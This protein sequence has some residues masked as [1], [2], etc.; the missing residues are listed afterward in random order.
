MLIGR[1]SR[2]P[3]ALVA[4][5]LAVAA[6]LVLLTGYH[7]LLRLSPRRVLARALRTRDADRARPSGPQRADGRVRVV[8]SA[9]DRAADVHPCRPQCLERALACRRLLRWMGVPAVLVLGVRRHGGGVEAHAWV[10]IESRS[11]D[12]RGGDFTPLTFLP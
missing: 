2:E 9:V 7:L 8:L 10:E 1:L 6:G 4:R 3:R 11:L 12:A 5:A